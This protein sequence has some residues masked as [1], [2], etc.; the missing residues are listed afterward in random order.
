MLAEAEAA[1][2][3]SATTAAVVQQAQLELQRLLH[4]YALDVLHAIA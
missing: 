1:A 2:G 3:I 4:Y